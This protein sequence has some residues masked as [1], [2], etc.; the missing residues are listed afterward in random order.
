[1]LTAVINVKNFIF[2]EKT[3]SSAVFIFILVSIIAPFFLSMNNLMNLSIQLGVYGIVAL[4]M[5]FAI[6][7]GEFDLSV[8]SQLSLACVL[9]VGLQPVT[10]LIPAVFAA[11]I[12]GLIMGTITTVILS[13]FK[14]ITS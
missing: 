3:F 9:T 12:S 11:V 7:G 1:M 14:S 4:G 5:T 2:K 13:K 6:I 8:G 10:G